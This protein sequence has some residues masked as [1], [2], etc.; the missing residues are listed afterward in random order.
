MATGRWESTSPTRTKN[1]V[2]TMSKSKKTTPAT[3]PETTTLEN[4]TAATPVPEPEP[5]QHLDD[6]ARRLSVAIDKGEMK[7][8]SASCGNWVTFWNA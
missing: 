2:K 6:D 4:T 5:S 8:S 7:A 1:E 3:T